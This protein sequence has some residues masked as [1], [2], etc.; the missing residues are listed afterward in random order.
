LCVSFKFHVKEAI[1]IKIEWK[2]KKT[3][4]DVNES[5]KKIMKQK[6]NRMVNKTQD[7]NEDKKIL[8]F[9]W[10]KRQQKNI[11]KFTHVSQWSEWEKNINE[12]KL[13]KATKWKK[14]STN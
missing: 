11:N 6:K 10:R 1:T 4:G 9:S 5:T 12:K 8:T 7:F 3:S 14:T 13:N 2:K